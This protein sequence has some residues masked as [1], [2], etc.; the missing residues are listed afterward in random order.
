MLIN[1]AYKSSRVLRELQMDGDPD[2][3]LHQQVLKAKYVVICTVKSLN[4]KVLLWEY[5]AWRRCTA[6]VAFALCH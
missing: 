4:T 6:G 5:F 3:S 2:P 1:V